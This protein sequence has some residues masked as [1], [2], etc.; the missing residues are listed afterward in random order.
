MVDFAELFEK[1][2]KR[3]GFADFDESSLSH[4]A[5]KT[6]SVDRAIEEALAGIRSN[7]SASELSFVD[8]ATKEVIGT[9]PSGI[10]RAL[11][12]Q[13][14][15]MSAPFGTITADE[16]KRRHREFDRVPHLLPIP[17]NPIHETNEHLS[18]LAKKFDALVDV[19]AKQAFVIDQLLESQK[20]NEAAQERASIRAHRNGVI[21][22]V[23]AFAA[24]IVSIIV[25][26]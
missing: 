6:H 22:I 8:R 14:G 2:R 19:Q 9:R 26:G 20:A 3:R 18:G 4:A 7:D 21:G 10:D 16:L 17:T 11:A 5:R 25:A 12:E 24:I 13:I 15:Q 23:L 1:P